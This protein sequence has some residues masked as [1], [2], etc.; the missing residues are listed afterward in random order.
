MIPVRGEV[1]LVALDPA[2]GDELKKMR[3]A[4]VMNQN[5][6]GVLNLRAIVPVTGWQAKFNGCDW[7]IRIDPERRNGLTKSSAADTFQVRCI[8]LQ[9][10]KRKLGTLSQN[11]IARIEEGLR[12]V[13]DLY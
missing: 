12:A 9:R 8:S 4:V 11:D 1:W 13:F 6:I 2:L 7:L 3:P 5:E 10:F